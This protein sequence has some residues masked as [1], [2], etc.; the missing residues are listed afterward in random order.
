[1]RRPPQLYSSTVRLR[2]RLT[3]FSGL[4]KFDRPSVLHGLK[5]GSLCSALLLLLLRLQSRSDEES[6][7]LWLTCKFR[8]QMEHRDLLGASTRTF[9]VQP[10]ACSKKHAVVSISTSWGIHRTWRAACIVQIP[11]ML[12]RGDLVQLPTELLNV[13]NVLTEYSNWWQGSAPR[14]SSASSWERGA[15][16]CCCAS[17]PQP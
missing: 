14:R 5:S 13:L 3:F 8:A 16:T 1:M 15:C 17:M 11:L 7:T 10:D 2:W 9:I 6:L 4:S 12:G